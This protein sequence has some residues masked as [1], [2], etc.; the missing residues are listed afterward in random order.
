MAVR[1]LIFI[2]NV[3]LQNPTRSR[4]N[5][6]KLAGPLN[7]GIKCSNVQP[8]YSEVGCNIARKNIVNLS[9]TGPVCVCVCVFRTCGYHLTH[10]E[11]N[12]IWVP[13]KYNICFSSSSLLLSMNILIVFWA[14]SKSSNNRKYIF[15][16][17][18]NT[19]Q[20]IVFVP[21]RWF[22]FFFCK[23]SGLF[24]NENL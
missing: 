13:V 1:W 3:F 19:F 14:S 4:K 9:A 12:N 7:F 11:D 24:F 15:L 10:F 20:S 18:N 17:F 8:L 23:S 6:Q 5:L 22:F 2:F 16:S 21:G